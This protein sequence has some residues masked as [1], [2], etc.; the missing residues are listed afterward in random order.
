MSAKSYQTV[1]GYSDVLNHMFPPAKKDLA[2]PD[3]S[4]LIIRADVHTSMH[5]GL[6]SPV[7]SLSL[8]THIGW[9]SMV[10]GLTPSAL[11]SESEAVSF[12][13]KLMPLLMSLGI[14]SVSSLDFG[15]LK[16]FLEKDSQVKIL[17][18]NGSD[19]AEL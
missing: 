15:K 2:L 6:P 11:H 3:G 7:L 10:E 4:V 14:T 1:S 18:R 8:T 13:M 9:Q 5:S 17:W 19:G 12:L 16:G